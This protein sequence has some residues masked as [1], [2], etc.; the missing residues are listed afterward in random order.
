MKQY[1]NIINNWGVSKMQSEALNKRIFLANQLAIILIIPFLFFLLSTLVF[2]LVSHFVFLSFS[3][4]TYLAV[5]LLNRQG[6]IN[7]SRVLLCI[8][9]T[10]FITTASIIAKLDVN[11]ANV[12]V[13]LAPRAFILC[14][15]V[16]PH[17]IFNYENGKLMWTSFIINSVCVLF[18]DELHFLFGIQISHLEYDA[19]KY[20]WFRATISIS[21]ITITLFLFVLQDINEKFQRRIEVQRKELLDLNRL[22]GKLLSIVSHDLRSPLGSLQGVLDLLSVDGLTPNQMSKIAVDLNEKISN[23]VD[24]M[25]NLLR[26]SMSQMDGLQVNFSAVNLNEVVTQTIRFLEP[27]INKKNISVINN[28]DNTLKLIAD[29]EMIKIIIR[30]IISNAIKFSPI[31][32]QIIIYTEMIENDEI[33]VHIKDEGIGMEESELSNL[34]NPSSHFSK[35]GTQNE[36][37][38]GLGLMLCKE[39]VEKQGGI[40]VVKSKKGKGSIFSFTFKSVNSNNNNLMTSRKLETV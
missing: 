37:G 31:N 20:E 11:E 30:N 29:Y 23:T 22:K 9:P 12:M 3:I 18:F 40:L 17:V 33:M 28:I 34:F 39:L 14:M 32:A 24:T 16:L 35:P 8:G 21:F 36:K 19:W 7:A 38:S 4:V 27:A 13:A 15:A 6:Y 10:I 25:D 2:G 26:W 5:P 1:L